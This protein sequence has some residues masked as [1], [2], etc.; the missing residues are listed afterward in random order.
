MTRGVVLKSAW[1]RARSVRECIQISH[2]MRYMQRYP[3]HYRLPQSKHLATKLT[4]SLQVN[5]HARKPCYLHTMKLIRRR[6][7]INHTFLLAIS[8]LFQVEVMVHMQPPHT[9]IIP[10]WNYCH[11]CTC[12]T[13]ALYRSWHIVT[14]MHKAAYMLS[15]P[16][17]LLYVQVQRSQFI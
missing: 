9:A 2:S 11:A 10:I 12:H 3:A 16:G 5:Y 7:K 6:Y 15:P 8:N 14:C 17:S 1:D 4:V 13:I